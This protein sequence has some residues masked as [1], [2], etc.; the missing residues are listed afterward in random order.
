MGYGV[1]LK[2]HQIIIVMMFALT[3]IWLHNFCWSTPIGVQ[4][5]FSLNGYST[6]VGTTNVSTIQS[7]FIFMPSFPFWWR[8][9][10]IPLLTHYLF[11]GWDADSWG[12]G[13][14]VSERQIW[15]CTVLSSRTLRMGRR[16]GWTS[17]LQQFSGFRHTSIDLFLT[18]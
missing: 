11:S 10:V 15:N 9:N 6:L 5:F 12:N 7:N 18:L 1:S 14:G 4:T 8:T 17:L 13:E 2:Y 3:F 16:E